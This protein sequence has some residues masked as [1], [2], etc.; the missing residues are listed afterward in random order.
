MSIPPRCRGHA[1]CKQTTSLA[2]SQRARCS[3]NLTFMSSFF[4][5]LMS[6]A[7]LGSSNCSFEGCKFV[8]NLKDFVQ[9]PRRGSASG[10]VLVAQL[11]SHHHC[12][13]ILLS[14]KKVPNKITGSFSPH[15]CNCL[16]C[17]SCNYDSNLYF[18]K[19]KALKAILGLHCTAAL[20]ISYF[21]RWTTNFG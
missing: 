9:Y 3:T 10:C 13:R 5:P 20:Y 6:D 15:F 1:G 19:Y 17:I 14:M 8:W 18:L 2:H 16:L 21:Q 4:L 7:D 11:H 12:K